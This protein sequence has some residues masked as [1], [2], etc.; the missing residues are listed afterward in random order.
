M[1]IGGVVRGMENV[2]NSVY[3]AGLRSA[4]A[5]ECVKQRVKGSGVHN[6]KST[7]FSTVYHR[8]FMAQ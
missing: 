4:G 7:G 8:N 5:Q 2:E 3:S 6:K 1:H